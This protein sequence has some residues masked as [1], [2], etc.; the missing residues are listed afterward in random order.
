[1]TL[2]LLSSPLSSVDDASYTPAIVGERRLLL[3]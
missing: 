1:L 3:D 2:F